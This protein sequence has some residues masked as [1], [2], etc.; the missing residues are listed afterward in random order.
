M[1]PLKNKVYYC[2]NDQHQSLNEC[3]MIVKDAA[4]VIVHSVLTKL[5]SKWKKDLD[6]RGL[7]AF[8]EYYLA[9]AER[10]EYIEN[11]KIGEFDTHLNCDSSEDGFDEEDEEEDEEEGEEGE[12]R[13]EE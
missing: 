7:D 13:E 4:N 9:P 12:E 6:E 1:P 2:P 10:I 3:H 11:V 5:V 8:K